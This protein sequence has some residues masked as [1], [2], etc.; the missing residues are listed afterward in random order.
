MNFYWSIN[1]IPELKDLTKEQ[2]KQAWQYCYKAYALKKWQS[3]VALMIL[4]VLCAFGNRYFGIIGS[5]VGAGIGG[6]IFGVM[7]TN[8]LRPH[9]AEY[10][11]SHFSATKTVNEE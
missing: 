2:A 6:G 11:N 1:Q 7:T 8:I 3:W 9:L 5:A 4:G 10:V